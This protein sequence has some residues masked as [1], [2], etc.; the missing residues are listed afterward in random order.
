M[1]AIIAGENG[2]RLILDGPNPKDGYTA[3]LQIESG[4]VSRTVHEFG[5]GLPGF[6]ADLADSWRG[7]PGPK[8]YRS[9]EGELELTAV[10]DGLG[11]VTLEVTVRQPWPPEW[12]ATATLDLGAG[13][14]FEA[15]AVTIAHWV[16][17]T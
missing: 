7:W 8:T 5:N 11:T 9:L 3:T 12:A 10:H 4:E 15:L 16:H 17:G 6:V 14:Q 2:R 13:A 1:N